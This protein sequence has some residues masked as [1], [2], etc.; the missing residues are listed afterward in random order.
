MQETHNKVI[1][2]ASDRNLI[3]GATSAAQY[4]KFLE[5]A[6][7]LGRALIE[8]DIVEIK[9]AIGDCMVVLTILAEQN[10]MSLPECYESA[11]DEI[12]DRTGK[13]INGVFVKD[14]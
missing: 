14:K 2:W 13:M 1:Q 11:Y 8:R 7:E 10:K 12:K 9:D 4:Q 5:E 6:G 3:K